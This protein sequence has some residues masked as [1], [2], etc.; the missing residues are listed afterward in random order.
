MGKKRHQRHSLDFLKIQDGRERLKI[1]LHK[2]TPIRGCYS[3]EL[4]TPSAK[5]KGQ[6]NGT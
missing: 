1:V 2:S 4:A 6:K 3:E 5:S